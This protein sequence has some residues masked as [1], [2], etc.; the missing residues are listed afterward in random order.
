MTLLSL[1]ST[2]AA[3]LCKRRIWQS[4]LELT[5]AFREGIWVRTLVD[6]AVAVI[7]HFLLFFFLFFLLSVSL[8]W[9]LR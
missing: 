9:L 8:I 7:L 1:L 3:E 2:D 5:H 4:V 6:R